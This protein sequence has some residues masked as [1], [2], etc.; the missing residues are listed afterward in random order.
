ME[1]L[2]L[3]MNDF[4][5]AEYDLKALLYVLNDLE[6][7]Y[8]EEEQMEMKANISVI[9]CCLTSVKA[10]MKATIGSLDEFIAAAAGSDQIK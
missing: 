1:E 4:L 9:K 2:Y 7:A 8:S 3:I 5:R 10:Q 6:A